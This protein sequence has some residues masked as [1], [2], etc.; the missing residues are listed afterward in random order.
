MLVVLLLG[1]VVASVVI[2]E[3]GRSN[4]W[5]YFWWCIFSRYSVVDRN[6]C[7]DNCGSKVVLIMMVLLLVVV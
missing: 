7:S 2:V 4:C 1:I 3:I 5:S 6:S